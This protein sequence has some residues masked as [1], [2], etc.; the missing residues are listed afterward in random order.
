[1]CHSALVWIAAVVTLGCAGRSEWELRDQRACRREDPP[2]LCVTPAPDRALV[3]RAGGAELVPGECAI[4]PHRRGGLLRVQA[5]DGRTGARG[6]RWLRVVRGKTTWVT[7]TAAAKP[8][9]TRT[10]CTSSVDDRER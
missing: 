6:R 3:V 1:M 2:R 7:P 10:R 5:E 4:S 8:R 9:A